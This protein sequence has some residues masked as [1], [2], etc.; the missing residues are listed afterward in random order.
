MGE[1]RH[2]EREP[3]TLPR[4]AALVAPVSSHRFC[5]SKARLMHVA[6]LHD[7]LSAESE[8]EEMRNWM[9]RRCP[10]FAHLLTVERRFGLRTISE[11]IWLFFSRM[12]FAPH[13]ATSYASV[14]TEESARELVLAVVYLTA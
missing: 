5:K 10:R 3:V 13:A 2:G 7:Q 6:W 14:C 4:G 11:L 1:T 12:L 8:K 9:A